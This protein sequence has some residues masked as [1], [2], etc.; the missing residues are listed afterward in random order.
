VSELAQLH[1][2]LDALIAEARAAL[3]HGD[4]ELGASAAS[5]MLVLATRICALTRVWSDLTRRR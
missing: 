4:R 3:A 5:G 2:A 1:R